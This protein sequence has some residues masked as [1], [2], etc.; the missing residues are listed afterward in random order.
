MIELI[1]A[2]GLG[3]QEDTV[4]LRYLMDLLNGQYS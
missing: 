1:H 3:I 4:E 2:F